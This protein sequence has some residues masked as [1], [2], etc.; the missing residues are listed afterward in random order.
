MDIYYE[1]CGQRINLAEIKDYRVIQREFIYRPAYKESDNT[2]KR[3][4]SGKR[5]EFLSMQPYAAIV[6]EHTRKAIMG[7]YKSKS[8]SE[9]LGKDV[10]DGVITTIADKLNLKAFK[11]KKFRCLNL[12][13]RE[14]YTYLE[15]VPAVIYRND[16]KV[17]DVHK[18]DELYPL[19]GETI[20]PTIEIV[21]VL[22]IKTDEVH[23]F[24][25]NGIQINDAYAEFK[26][27]S[28]RFDEYKSSQ[29]TPLLEDKPNRYLPKSITLKLPMIPSKKID[30]TK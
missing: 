14:F 24:Y 11:Y 10:A 13:G 22:I 4:F 3:F 29:E 28:I 27:L 12:A 20:S 17:S 16:G 9:S 30:K 21:P 2:V 5:F 8:F 19:L 25:G 26:Q 7:E 18:N 23:H 1:L 15:D 6:G